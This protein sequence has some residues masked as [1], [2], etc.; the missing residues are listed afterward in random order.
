MAFPSHPPAD[1]RTGVRRRGCGS[2]VLGLEPALRVQGGLAARTGGGDGLAVGVVLHV[3]AGE[4][5]LDVG[6]RC[7]AP[8]ARDQIAVVLRSEEHTSELQSLMRN[9]YAFFCLKKN[10]Q[11][12]T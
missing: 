2:V 5:A 8:L 6:R 4:H 3:A 12:D 7:A 1:T 9:T 10:K 11:E